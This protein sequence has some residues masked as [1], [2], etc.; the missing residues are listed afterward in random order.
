M[1]WATVIGDTWAPTPTML[2]DDEELAAV[3]KVAHGRGTTRGGPRS[4]AGSVKMAVRPRSRHQPATLRLPTCGGAL[5]MVESVK[6]R[7]FVAPAVEPPYTP[8]YMRVRSTAFGPF[9]RSAAVS[10]KPSSR[11][12]P[13]TWLEL[14]RRSAPCPVATTDS[15][16]R[17]WAATRDIG[18]IRDPVRPPAGGRWPVAPPAGR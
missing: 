13:T 9:A 8:T 18:V 4:S 10:L 6:D 11:S 14:H 3:V 1:P 2:I 16:A 12:P 17:R 5:D 7:V 15:C